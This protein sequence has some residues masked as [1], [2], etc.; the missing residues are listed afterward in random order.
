MADDPRSAGAS[1][2]Q[3]LRDLLAVIEAGDYPDPGPA[4]PETLPWTLPGSL[5]GSLPGPLIDCL[6]RVFHCQ[7]V[8]CSDLDPPEDLDLGALDRG[9]LRVSFPAAQHGIHRLTLWRTDG[10]FTDHEQLLLHL[11]RPHLQQAYLAAEHRRHTLP[12]LTDR[13]HEIVELV[14]RGLS[15]VE[16]AAALVISAGTVRKHLENVYRRTGVHNRTAAAHL[17]DV[18]PGEPGDGPAG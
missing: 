1:P 8:T 6:Q 18:E 4:L 11:L 14:A 9:A 7:A 12:W 2:D 3:D 17:L 10:E 5:P 13:E 15:N 16:I